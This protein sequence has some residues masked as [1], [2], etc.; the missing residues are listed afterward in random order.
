[1]TFLS[2]PVLGAGWFWDTGNA[3]GFTPARAGVLYLTLATG[4]G[5]DVRVHRQLGYA[6][7]SVAV[8]HAL[9]LLVGDPATIEYLKPGAPPYMW[10]GVLGLLLLAALTVIALPRVRSRTAQ[11]LQQFSA[12][13][14]HHRGYDDSRN[15]VAYRRQQLLPWQLV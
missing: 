13:A 2:S 14:S 4:P 9:W 1:M 8:A 6:V 11:T 15:D 7:L 3:L 10:A 5:L 12:V